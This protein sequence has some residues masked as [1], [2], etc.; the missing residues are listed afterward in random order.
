MKLSTI[1]KAIWVIFMLLLLFHP[2]LTIAFI[3]SNLGLI[4]GLLL[5]YFMIRMLIDTTLLDFISKEIEKER[6]E[7]E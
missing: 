6:K 4:G 7:E 5:I 3:V 1:V 2:V